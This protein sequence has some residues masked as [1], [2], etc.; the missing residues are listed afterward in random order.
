MIK[1]QFPN[2]I[3]IAANAYKMPFKKDVFDGGLMVRVLH[4]IERREKYIK[5]L[6]RVLK[7][8]A[9]YIQEY[10]NKIHLKARV[11]AFLR[12][13]KDFNSLE[14]F[15]QP[16]IHLEGAKGDGVQFLNYHPKYIEK[17]F[18]QEDFEIEDKQGCSFL[19][20]PLLKKVFGTNILTFIEKCLQKM[21]PKSNIPPSIFIKTELEVGDDEGEY[22][23]LKDILACPNCK[24]SLSID[25]NNCYC[26]KCEK[27]YFRKN[28][29]WDFR[30]E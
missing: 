15:Q 21:F 17:L 8:D 2:C 25:E 20:V 1:G 30:I 29:V 16:T 12:K 3:L 4:H 26:E 14:P 9:E 7:K 11:R 24:S 5:E 28:G 10:A 19:R 18:E 27:K 22:P 23:E 6:A 13:D